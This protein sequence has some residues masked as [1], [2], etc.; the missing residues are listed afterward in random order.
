MADLVRVDSAAHSGHCG[1]VIPVFLGLASVF[2]VSCVEDLPADRSSADARVVAIPLPA[3]P[4]AEASGQVGHSGQTP[5]LPERRPS[6][7]QSPAMNEAPT[8]DA[9]LTFAQPTPDAADAAPS[10]TG[11]DVNQADTGME[12]P[13]ANAPRPNDADVERDVPGPSNHLGG[14]AMHMRDLSDAMGGRPD[15]LE[16]GGDTARAV[17]PDECEHPWPDPC[18]I[19]CTREPMPTALLHVPIDGEHRLD[20]AAPPYACVLVE[21]RLIVENYQ[22]LR[23]TR[24]VLAETG[25]IDGVGRAAGMASPRDGKEGKSRYGRGG[26]GSGGSGVC[27]GGAGSRLTDG[28]NAV[29]AGRLAPQYDQPGGGGGRGGD[30]QGLGGPGGFGGASFGLAAEHCL[31]GG[32]IDLSGR[33]GS[34][35]LGSDGGG[36]GGGSSG[37]LT[38]NCTHLTLRTAR[39]SIRL[40]G[41]DGGRGGSVRGGN[42]TYAGGG[43]GGGAGGACRIETQV[44]RMNDAV[45][46]DFAV[47]NDELRQRLVLDGGQGGDHGPGGNDSEVGDDGDDCTLEVSNFAPAA[48]IDDRSMDR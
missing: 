11:D 5:D 38:I 18:A 46:E 3:P 28:T 2:Q 8:M 25:F 40:T 29:T 45:V 7:D 36:G 17:E 35:P 15:P 31:I 30:K 21:G 22:E 47:F 14:Q 37:H 10:T 41:G 34:T 20:R 39:L 32:R 16:V 26:G 44:A 6:A 33:P 42:E 43:G 24:F 1:I 48:P 9:T 27:G 4:A 13:V 12:A 19:D 23:A